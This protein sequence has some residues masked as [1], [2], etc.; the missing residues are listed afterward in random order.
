MSRL[1]NG[2]GGHRAA[3]MNYLSLS[4]CLALSS[5]AEVRSLNMSMR[6]AGLTARSID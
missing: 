1:K 2:S 3:M 5:V 4:D 6:T